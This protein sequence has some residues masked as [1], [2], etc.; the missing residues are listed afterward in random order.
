MIY[1]LEYLLPP[2]LVNPHFT[3]DTVH[4]GFDL[5]TGEM[6]TRHKKARAKKLTPEE[7]EKVEAKRIQGTL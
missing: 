1:S 6:T 3:P 2:K 5:R 7:F 4:S